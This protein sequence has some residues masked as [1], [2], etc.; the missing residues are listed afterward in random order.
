MPRLMYGTRSGSEK[1]ARRK[2]RPR[3]RYRPIATAAGTAT[4]AVEIVTS[5][6]TSRLVRNARKMFGTVTAHS[7]QRVVKA[8]GNRLG[9]NHCCATDQSTSSG[10]NTNPAKTT[11]IARLTAER[12]NCGLSPGLPALLVFIGAPSAAM[13]PAQNPTPD[14]H[15]DRDL[16]HGHD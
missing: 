3:N 15:E 7:Y 13:R 4:T 9:Q 14:S 5:T 10:P 8:L 12:A 11:V 2:S 6:A 1:T 16:N